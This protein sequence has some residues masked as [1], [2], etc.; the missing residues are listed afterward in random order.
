M[1]SKV[2]FI[3]CIFAFYLLIWVLEDGY[4]LRH[5]DLGAFVP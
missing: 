4:E 2:G 1:L 3:N 5:L